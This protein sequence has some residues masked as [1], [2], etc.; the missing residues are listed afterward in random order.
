MAVKTITVDL[1]AYDLLAKEK[2]MGESFSQVI[3]RKSGPPRAS[4]KLFH[5]IQGIRPQ[6]ARAA[7]KHLVQSRK[8]RAR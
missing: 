7:R 8:E 5:R 6:T 3:K 4:R 1:E 2:Q